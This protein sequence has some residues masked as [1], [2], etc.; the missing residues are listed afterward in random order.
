MDAAV[1]VRRAIGAELAQVQRRIG[2]AW[3]DPIVV[4]GRNYPVGALDLC[5][6]AG[7]FDGVLAFEVDEK[8][9]CELVAIIAQT[10][11]R[12][13]GTALIAAL[14]RELGDELFVR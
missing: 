2:E 1:E 12:G 11:W 8:P 4:R 13:A 9:V 6:I 3:G 7:D 14:R 5:L 10:P